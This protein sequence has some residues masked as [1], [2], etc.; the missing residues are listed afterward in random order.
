MIVAAR[1]RMLELRR[2]RARARS[3]R[4]LLLKI[5]ADTLATFP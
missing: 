5:F 4:S 2:L 1:A 3:R